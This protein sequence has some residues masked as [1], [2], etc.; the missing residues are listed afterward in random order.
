MLEKTGGGG[1][2]P[3]H[4]ECPQPNPAGITLS[5][6]HHTLPSEKLGLLLQREAPLP[7]SGDFC[8]CLMQTRGSS[9]LGQQANSMGGYPGV[10]ETWPCTSD[11]VVKLDC[12]PFTNPG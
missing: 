12:W 3:H 8:I 6:R 2:I 5:N 10:G 11:P 4:S 1:G 7:F 9:P